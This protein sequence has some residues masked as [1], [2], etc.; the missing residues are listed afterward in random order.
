[1]NFIWYGFQNYF[2]SLIFPNDYFMRLTVTFAVSHGIC[3]FVLLIQYKIFKFVSKFSLVPRLIVED[4]MNI[5]MII[6]TTVYWKFYW[7]LCDYL[8]YNKEILLYLY[9]AGH[10]ISF[11]FTVL[12][13]IT[14]VLVGPDPGFFDGD[15]KF[16]KSYFDLNFASDNFKVYI[17][18]KN[19][20]CNF[21]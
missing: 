4:S 13:N 8:F 17:L 12:C 7:D 3:L 2:D 11:G 20:I 14:G 19:R 15:I 5:I 21:F 18:F 6:T 9:L 1:M 16:T 10:L